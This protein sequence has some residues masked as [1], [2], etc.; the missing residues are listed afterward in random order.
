MSH[1][2]QFE[3]TFDAIKM[4]LRELGEFTNDLGL[5]FD[6]TEWTINRG[7]KAKRRIDF[8]CATIVM[9]HGTMVEGG[10]EQVYHLTKLNIDLHWRKDKVFSYGIYSIARTSGIQIFKFDKSLLSAKA[11]ATI[12][13]YISKAAVANQS[14][15]GTEFLPKDMRAG[16]VFL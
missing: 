16:L 3:Q 12:A 8:Y 7:L 15:D 6:G 2:S 14:I 10:F 13:E 1:N 9:R 5:T 11:K 4:E